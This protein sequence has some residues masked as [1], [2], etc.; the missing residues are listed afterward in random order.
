MQLLMVPRDCG[1]VTIEQL[2]VI[3]IIETFSSRLEPTDKLRGKGRE[4]CLR[5]LSLVM[6]QTR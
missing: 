2:I 3:Q 4:W 1:L 6:Q 5:R